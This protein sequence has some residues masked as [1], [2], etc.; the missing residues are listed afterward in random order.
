MNG[1]LYWNRKWLA[2]SF[3]NSE[4]S[5]GN[6]YFRIPYALNK[7]GILDMKKLEEIVRTLFRKNSEFWNCY[8]EL[9]DEINIAMTNDQFITAI[10]V[11]S[12]QNFYNKYKKED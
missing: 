1:V 8:I 10:V 7:N 4:Q 5:G 2:L 3:W 12:D 11:T 9:G 6:L